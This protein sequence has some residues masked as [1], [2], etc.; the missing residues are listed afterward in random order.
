MASITLGCGCSLEEIEDPVREGI[1]RLGLGVWQHT[2][3]GPQEHAPDGIWVD[4]CGHCNYPKPLLLFIAQMAADRVS[5][6]EVQ[7]G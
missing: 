5:L 7:D 6:L 4:H 1:C 2:A 3:G